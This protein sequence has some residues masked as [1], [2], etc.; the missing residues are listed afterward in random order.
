MTASQPENKN[1][2]YIIDPTFRNINRLLLFFFSFK[3]GK[4]DPTIISF[5]KYYDKWVNVS[6][7]YNF[8]FHE[9]SLLNCSI[10]LSIIMTERENIILN[11]I[12]RRI[13]AT[14]NYSIEKIKQIVSMS[15]KH[16]RFVRLQ[17]LS[18]NHLFYFLMLLKAFQ[19]LLFI[20]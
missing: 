3:A 11:F 5:D 1:L 7:T 2:N 9:E 16:K 8:M 17:T 20:N 14:R 19:F 4:N 13:D 18:N 10:F 12:L 15:K 6:R